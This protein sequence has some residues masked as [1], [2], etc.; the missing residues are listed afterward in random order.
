MTDAS[1]R[2]DADFY[3]EAGLRFKTADG[4]K[5]DTNFTITGGMNRM[6]LSQ[7]SIDFDTL[8]PRAVQML[9]YEA[10]L[11]ESPITKKRGVSLK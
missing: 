11:K 10:A 4:T 5:P 9:K 7:A 6:H 2:R 8:D 1:P 3:E